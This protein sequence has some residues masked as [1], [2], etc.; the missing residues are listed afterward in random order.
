MAAT[1][2]NL[3]NPKE[4]NNQIAPQFDLNLQFAKL[5]EIYG[6]NDIVSERKEYLS[7]TIQKY[8]YLPYPHFKT[9]EELS[10]GEIIFTFCEKLKYEG[11]YDGEKF[12]NFSNPSPLARRKVKHSNW[13]KKEG[14][15]I[16]LLSLSGLGKNPEEPGKFIDWMAAVISLDSGNNELNIM[17]CTLYLIPFH[18]REFECAYLPK[19]S[20]VSKN[21][22]DEK[23]AKFLGLDAKAQVKFFIT[24]AQLAG[25][26]VIYDI[27]PQTGR[28]SKIVLSKPYVARWFDIKELD[29]RIANFKKVLKA[30]KTLSYDEDLRE[31]KILI[32]YKMSFKAKQEE[33][34]K[35][36]EE[37]IEFVNGKKPKCEEDI[38]NQEEIIK[39]LTGAGLWPSPGGAWCSAGVP[40]YDKMHKS[41]DYP[42]FKH[43]NYK[44]E[45]VSHFANLDCQ[46]PYY[47]V[48]FEKHK[49]N[50]KV[51]NFFIDYTQK[52][53]KEYNFDGF[54]V[55]HIDH[56]VDEVSQKSNMP[57][58]YRVPY[59]VLCKMNSGI[60][61][62]TPYFATLAEYMLWDGYF[63][64][65]HRDM[66]FDL[67]WGD[68]IVSQYIKTPEQ[69]INDNLRLE[70]Y[71]TKGP[72]ANPLSILK[73]YN[74]QD[75]EFRDIDQY[76][77][78]L[79]ETGALFKWFKYKFLPGG[80]FAQRSTLFVDGD[81]SFTKTGIERIIGKEVSM[82]RNNDWSFY[83]KFNAVNYFAQHSELLSRGKAILHIQS[84]DGFCCW[85]IISDK[86]FKE[87][88]K[89]SLFVVANYLAPTEK[90][91]VVD[92][93]GN[94]KRMTKKGRALTN[95]TIKLKDNKKLVSFYDF[96]LDEMQKC[97][98]TEI[99]MEEVITGSITFEVLQPSE[100][101]V[102]R[103]QK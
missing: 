31:F 1:V 85:E 93:E 29:S 10:A 86:N 51:A 59:K 32:S 24:L 6:A 80:K 58:S 89:E 53:Q 37:I 49:F 55:D 3:I 12:I 42:T 87:S 78:Q 21:L 81:E 7:K 67:L 90:V 84:E 74:N 40:V 26:P 50:K 54:R 73:A 52:L 48:F 45:D 97:K 16:K 100:F 27:L 96:R 95:K 17:P 65:Y 77:G 61:K 8:G 23:I 33:L 98:F 70:T 56:V 91:N 69:I 14:H 71:N 60:K 13:F 75:G 79:G 34:Q 103:M 22:E 43:Y 5:K 35:R 19:S 28:F 38:T 76:P 2:L 94:S 83:E 47:F 64:E 72:K 99:P 46:T 66:N 92:V 62:Q 44:G 15:N 9:L 20:D 68:D 36:A 18:P 63:K 102:Y 82:I 25:H 57:I 30:N 11:T 41:G 101:K 88:Q 4:Q 39:A